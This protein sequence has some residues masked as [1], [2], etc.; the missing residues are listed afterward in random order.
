MRDYSPPAGSTGST[1]A[2]AK[3]HDGVDLRERRE[4]WTGFGDTLSRAME[5]AVTPIVFGGIG[6]LVDSWLG[7][8]PLFVIGL[9]VFAFVGLFVRMWIGYDAEMRRQ[10]EGKPWRSVRPVDS[11][12]SHK[13]LKKRRTT[14]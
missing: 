1:V 13:N 11:P 6:W 3:G 2:D 14:A 10:E 9:V 8:R 4:T 12:L 5:F 7:T